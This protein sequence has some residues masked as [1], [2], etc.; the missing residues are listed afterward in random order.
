[1]PRAKVFDETKV[2]QKAMELFWK[3]G[4]HATSIQDLVDHLGINRA[5]IYN[6]Y[7]SKE[8]L[9]EKAFRYYQLSNR[10][11]I[12]DFLNRHS[13]VKN[14]LYKLFEQTII[15]SCED[16]DRKGCFVVNTTTE[17]IPVNP[18]LQTVLAE[19]KQKFEE[20]F[21]QYLKQGEELEQIAPNKDLKAISTL[22][23]TLYNGLQV[24]IKVTDDRE[25]LLN[26]IK[27]A[28]EVLD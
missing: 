9:F 20:L 5:S 4:F 11:H 23:F 26:T 12:I 22:L 19:N 16:V 18:F 25:G 28:L 21:Y 1:M 14:G 3:Q 8:S 17:L 6:A 2:L 24:V 27:V 13:D 10:E 15:Q 7:G